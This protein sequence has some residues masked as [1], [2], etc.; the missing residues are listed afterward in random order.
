MVF[1]EW[2]EYKF[3][4]LPFSA[5]YY[6]VKVLVI[7]SFSSNSVI[8][9]DNFGDFLIVLLNRYFEYNF[10]FQPLEV[11]SHQFNHHDNQSHL[12]NFVIRNW[13]DY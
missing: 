2:D 3:Y 9:T 1:T 6:V 7:L 8:L 5:N 11:I 13:N 4:N 10:L 12:D